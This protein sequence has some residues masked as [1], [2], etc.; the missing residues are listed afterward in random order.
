MSFADVLRN[1]NFNTYIGLAGVIGKIMMPWASARDVYI[2]IT[3]TCEC[4]RTKE[5]KVR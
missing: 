5:R 1:M 3:R 2:L 4:Y